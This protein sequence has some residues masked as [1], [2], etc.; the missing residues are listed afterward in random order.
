MTPDMRDGVRWSANAVMEHRGY[1]S[2]DDDHAAPM[3]VLVARAVLAFVPPG[4]V[5]APEGWTIAPG[6]L[7]GGEPTLD[8]TAPGHRNGLGAWLRYADAERLA[9]ALLAAV[10]DA[11]RAADTGA[12]TKGA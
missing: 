12:A 8:I 3:A 9:W 10:A 11:R 4:D 6:S 2:A 7:Y 5:Q 1:P